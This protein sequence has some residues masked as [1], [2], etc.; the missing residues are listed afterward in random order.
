MKKKVKKIYPISLI[1]DFQFLIWGQPHK[2]ID[3]HGGRKI[4]E[5]KW[6]Y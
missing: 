4:W 3:F 2:L 1:I 5:K 6:W